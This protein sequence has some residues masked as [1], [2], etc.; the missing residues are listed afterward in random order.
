MRP[1][2]AESVGALMIAPNALRI[3]DDI[4]A[5]P[6][7]RSRGY[8][9][10]EV[11]FKDNVDNMATKHSEYLGKLFSKSSRLWPKNARSPSPMGKSFFAY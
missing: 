9:F 2:N 5:Y 7:I 4:G 10:E 8:N 1:H 6:R 11:L 3:L